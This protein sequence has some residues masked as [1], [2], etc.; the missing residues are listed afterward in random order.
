MFT[1]KTDY[2]MSNANF[3]YIFEP[4]HRIEGLE[5]III[6]LNKTLQTF[7][8]K[9]KN[10]NYYDG[11][12]YREE[13]ELIYGVLLVSVQNYINKT[14]YDFLEAR[15]LDKKDI[16]EYYDINSEE[17]F[18]GVSQIRLIIELANYF[19]HRDD[20]SKISKYTQDAFDKLKI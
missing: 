19:K 14:C 17:I 13:T 2:K 10:Y 16:Y 3:H 1:Q 5:L 8:E 15:I 18:H 9:L 20:N 7:K 12:W 11:D 4:D 6:G